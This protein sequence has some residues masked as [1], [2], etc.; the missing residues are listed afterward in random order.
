MSIRSNYLGAFLYPKKIEIRITK[1]EPNNQNQNNCENEYT[2][3]LEN[4]LLIVQQDIQSNDNCDT[5]ENYDP[6]KP[7]SYEKVN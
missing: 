7:N 4:S 5:D 6:S 2:K 3:N 1:E